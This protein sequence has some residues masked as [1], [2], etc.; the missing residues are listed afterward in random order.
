[1]RASVMTIIV[2]AGTGFFAVGCSQSALPTAPTAALSIAPA[3]GGSATASPVRPAAAQKE[4]PFKG[5]MEGVDSDSD[6]IPGQSV[7]VTTEGTGN[8]TELGYF[9]F[10]QRVTVFFATGTDVGTT[11]WVAANGDT[12]ETTVAGS[13]QLI[14]PG[15]ISITD[16]HTITGGTGRFAGAQ[17]TFTVDRVARAVA[18][19]TTSGSFDGTITSPGSSH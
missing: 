16:H 10:K 1:M 3:I 14:G 6:F 13:G 17:G 11:S 8:A 18:P 15:E 19:L 9:S 12:L 4:V 5:R 7:V 2:L